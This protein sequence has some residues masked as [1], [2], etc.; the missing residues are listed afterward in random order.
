MLNTVKSVKTINFELVLM[1]TNQDTYVVA[2]GYG[3]EAPWKSE[4]LTLDTALGLFD[5]LLELLNKRSYSIN[6]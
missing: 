1:D 6:Q 5:S 4:Y 3:D 2:Y